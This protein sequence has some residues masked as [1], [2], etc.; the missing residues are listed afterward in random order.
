MLDKTNPG[1]FEDVR[2]AHKGYT[3]RACYVKPASTHP[4]PERNSLQQFWMVP[5]TCLD[6][7]DHALSTDPRH[8]LSPG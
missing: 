8:F 5:P 1:G 3:G 6:G 7:V 4:T 2:I